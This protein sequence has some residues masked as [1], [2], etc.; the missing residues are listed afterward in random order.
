MAFLAF[1]VAAA[2]LAAQVGSEV[3]LDAN[4]QIFTVLCAARAAGLEPPPGRG[5]SEPVISQVEEA[6]AQL[7]PSVLAP[8][9]AFFAEK[10][11]G[12]NPADVSAYVSLGL[13]LGPPPEFNS[14][15]PRN[16]LPPDVWRLKESPPLIQAFSAQAKLERLW[17]QVLPFYEQAIAERQAAVAQV[18]LE[19]RGYLRLI[20]ERYPGRTYTIYLE[21]LVPRWLT[22]A[23][24]Y[25]DDY[26]LVIHPQRSDFL[27]AV[28]HQ[29]LHFLLDPIAAK[30]A[31]A[32]GS[33]GRLQPVVER[34]AGLPLA[35]RQDTLLL[36]TESLIQALELRL[37]QPDPGA[38]LTDLEAL[39]RS[40]YIFV[41]H[42]FRALEQFEKAEPSIRFYFPELL[43]GFNVE[44]ERARLQRVE[45]AAPAPV[46]PAPA[47]PPAQNP[48]ARLLA[49]ADNDLVAGDYASAR[50]RFERVLKEADPNEPR[51]LYG[52]AILAS[53]AQNRE[54]A[55]Y[56]FGRTLEQARTPRIVG[57]THVYLARIYDLEGRREQA[58][59][60]YRAALV[61]NTRLAKL[62]EAAR[63]GLERPFGAEQA[64][65]PRNPPEG[66]RP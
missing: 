48:I 38:A 11:G 17:S 55:K 5:Q 19:T 56:Y 35:F 15:F 63:R 29:Y 42:F 23:R 53:L 18:L 1:I 64:P 34:A 60:H 6:L 46:A 7:D 31:G 52:L 24:N 32:M 27:D 4:R 12:R 20:G 40:G 62:E 33:W 8:V 49:E 41:R 59:A 21:W 54:Q 9:R 28:R 43:R 22:S 58:V 47:A 66:E 37:R 57:W 16:Q 50:K 2:P 44:R 13:L 25:G 65:E 51:A 30:H 45:F 36:A 3:Q 26:F 61:L 10:H 14:V 39:E